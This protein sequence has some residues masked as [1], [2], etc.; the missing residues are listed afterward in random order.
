MGVIFVMKIGKQDLLRYFSNKIEK[1]KDL[2][3]RGIIEDNREVIN[4]LYQMKSTVDHDW[5]ENPELFIDENARD[6]KLIDKLK[7][8]EDDFLKLSKSILEFLKQ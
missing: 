4:F 7:I 3:A 8:V 5:D 6:Q 1:F 2:K